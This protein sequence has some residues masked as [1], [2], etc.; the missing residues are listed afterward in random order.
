MQSRFL[1]A[2]NRDNVGEFPG[3]GVAAA[4]QFKLLVALKLVPQSIFAVGEKVFGGARAAVFG[5]DGRRRTHDNAVSDG[6]RHAS[7][8]VRSWKSGIPLDG[9]LSVTNL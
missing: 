1:P 3:D 4:F 8:G 2:V 5:G 6:H 9:N 7:I